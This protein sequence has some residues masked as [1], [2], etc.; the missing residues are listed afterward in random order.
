MQKEPVL[1]SDERARRLQRARELA[2]PFERPGVLGALLFGSLSRPYADAASDIDVQIVVEDDRLQALLDEQHE[3]SH[4]DD[5]AKVADVSIVSRGDLEGTVRDAVRRRLA[6]AI[7]LFDSGELAPLKTRVSA[8]PEEKRVARLKVHYFEMTYLINKVRNAERRGGSDARALLL[9]ELTI[10]IAKLCFAE[11]G[12]YPPPIT[13]LFD[14][15]EVLGAPASIT[16]PLRALGQDSSARLLRRL[17]ADVDSFLL[18]RGITF[19]RDPEAVW[20]WIFHTVD[21]ARS[22][23][24]LGGPASRIG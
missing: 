17:R 3:D 9:A 8:M 13:W 5:G 22:V 7:I 15:L 16:A 23:A 19:I 20:R 14:E 18:D 24:E 6:T 11:A 1:S 12:Q 10:A 21:G 2:A 4:Y